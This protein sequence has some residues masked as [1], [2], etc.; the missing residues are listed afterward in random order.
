[1][2]VEVPVDVGELDYLG[3]VATLE[4]LG[5]DLAEAL[6]PLAFTVLEI[7][8]KNATIMASVSFEILQKLHLLLKFGKNLV[9]N[10]ESNLASM[11]CLNS[12]N[13]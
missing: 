8:S 6:L 5:D 1:V 9:I 4:V 13:Y 10:N 12:G 2:F 3:G 11:I 7:W